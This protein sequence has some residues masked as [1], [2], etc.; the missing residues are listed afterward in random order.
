MNTVEELNRAFQYRLDGNLDHWTILKPD[1][2]G[3]VRGDCEDY[4]LTVLFLL[5]NK[6]MFRFWIALIFGN[7]KIH[8]GK[9]NG[10]GHAI[11][12]YQGRYIDNITR[13]WCGTTGICRS[14]FKFKPWQFFWFQ[15]AIKM[16]VAKLV[17]QK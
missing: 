4:A 8:Y 6:S 10:R 15:V 9:V 17:R 14:G 5:C 3:I 11:L 12:E 13:K 7:A 16:L 2:N 1:S